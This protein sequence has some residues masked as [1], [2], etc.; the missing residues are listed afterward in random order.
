[1]NKYFITFLSFLSI[2]T[3]ILNFG[4]NEAFSQTY[5]KIDVN[6]IP[7]LIPPYKMDKGSVNNSSSIA[8]QSFDIV[9]VPHNH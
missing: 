2:V 4:L 1:M 5:I 7:L 6:I 9:F 8:Q 3:I